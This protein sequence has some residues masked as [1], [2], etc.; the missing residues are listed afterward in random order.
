M[1]DAIAD[2]DSGD[3]PEPLALP[4]EAL[5]LT[6][7]LKSSLVTRS[8]ENVSGLWL[9]PP[10]VALSG[11]FVRAVLFMVGDGYG[12]VGLSPRDQ[13]HSNSPRGKHVVCC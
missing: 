3:M 12:A 9:A 2:D 4:R 13:L 8:L 7:P 10:L 1:P 5:L 6:A 11:S